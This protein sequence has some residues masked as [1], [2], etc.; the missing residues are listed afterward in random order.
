M[1]REEP[2]RRIARSSYAFFLLTEE[3]EEI[4]PAVAAARTEGIEAHGPFPPD[5]VFREAISGRFGAIV[6]RYHDQGHIP[7]KLLDF[8]GAVNVMI[9]LRARAKALRRHISVRGFRR[10]LVRRI[11]S[12]IVGP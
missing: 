11:L 8:E 3:G 4:A 2:T 5:A 7:M 10:G 6:C 1:G 9:G 12:A